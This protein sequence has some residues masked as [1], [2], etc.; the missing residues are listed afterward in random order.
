M[1]FDLFD[2]GVYRIII[3]QSACGKICFASCNCTGFYFHEKCKHV[4]YAKIKGD[5]AP[6]DIPN[7]T[8]KTTL[9]K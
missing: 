9:G 7:N 6:H 8:T 3:H 4:Q 5:V 2:I 1:T